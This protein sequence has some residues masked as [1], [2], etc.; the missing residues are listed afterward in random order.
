MAK[1]KTL[2]FDIFKQTGPSRTS[3]WVMIQNG[4]VAGRIITAWPNDGAG[5]VKVAVMAWAGVLKDYNA[6]LG[7]AGGYGYD[8]ESAAIQDALSRHGI[9]SAD[10]SGR[11]MGAVRD[12]FAGE[13]YELQQV[14]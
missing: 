9:V 5:R 3:V 11:G 7:Q 1:S 12:W 13:G 14:L 4:K 10:L 8:K 2:N 6:M